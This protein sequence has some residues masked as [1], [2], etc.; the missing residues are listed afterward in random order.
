MFT[1]CQY[2][3]AIWKNT[4]LFH[5]KYF[6]LNLCNLYIL[7]LL[8]PKVRLELN[9]I[10]SDTSG[11][12]TLSSNSLTPLTNI[13]CQPW[14][15]QLVSVFDYR[16]LNYRYLYLIGIIPDMSN[17]DTLSNRYLTHL[18]N[19]YCLP[20][21]IVKSCCNQLRFCRNDILDYVLFNLKKVMC[22]KKL[23]SFLSRNG[24]LL[25]RIDIFLLNIN[26]NISLGLLVTETFTFVIKLIKLIEM[27]FETLLM[28][29][30]LF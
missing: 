16:Y 15:V 2:Y 1:F 8:F 14:K 7:L 26:Q 9:G 19:T 18:I 17:I 25:D 5:C 28:Y 21:K 11:F 22:R 24:F 12:P 29:T 10:I 30:Y 4:Y 3:C 20:Q 23:K 13:Y 6:N 27:Y